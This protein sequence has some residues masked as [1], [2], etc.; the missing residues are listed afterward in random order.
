MKLRFVGG[1][2]YFKYDRA[3]NKFSDFERSITEPIELDVTLLRKW[4]VPGKGM[5]M[6]YELPLD[7]GLPSVYI[8]AGVPFNTT[9]DDVGISLGAGGFFG[10]GKYKERWWWYWAIALIVWIIYRLTKKNKK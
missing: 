5:D 7:D 10:L 8:H 9:T 3:T 2:I 1:D 6:A 4:E